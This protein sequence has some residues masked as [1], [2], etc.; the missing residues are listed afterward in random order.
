MDKEMLWV[1]LGVLALFLVLVAI[2][3]YLSGHDP[4]VAGGAGA[5]AAA[6][7]EAARRKREELKR[8]VDIAFNF[9]SKTEAEISALETRTLG[10][11]TTV[12]VEIDELTRDEKEALGEDLFGP[13]T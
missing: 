11:A 3:M 7:A 13:G 4:V 1:W 9:G 6:S 2:I 8:Q 5:A 12:T 10:E